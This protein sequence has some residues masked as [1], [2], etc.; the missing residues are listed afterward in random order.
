MNHMITHWWPWHEPEDKQAACK[1]YNRRIKCSISIIYFV[2]Q[3]VTQRLSIKW[4]INEIKNICFQSADG[5]IQSSKIKMYVPVYW[6]LASKYGIFALI[7]FIEVLFAMSRF[8][9][10]NVTSKCITFFQK[11]FNLHIEVPCDLRDVACDA[12]STSFMWRFMMVI[13]QENKRHI[14][15]ISRP[16]ICR[17]MAEEP[18]NV[19]AWTPGHSIFYSWRLGQTNN[20]FVSGIPPILANGADPGTFYGQIK[21]YK[22][23][24]DLIF[25]S[26]PMTFYRY[27]AFTWLDINTNPNAL[28]WRGKWHVRSH[29]FNIF[30]DVY[31]FRFCNIS[32]YVKIRW[33]TCDG[34]LI[35]CHLVNVFYHSSLYEIRCIPI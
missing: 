23:V 27:L 18:E 8:Q 14:S 9:S 32:V 20:T 30:K 6:P 17:Y 12:Q 33:K 3:D 34:F 24:C 29:L 25:E 2:V 15:L 11:R 28:A 21:I 7:K 4:Y 16:F 13:V 31:H 19:V 22:H 1:G 10:D 5:S 35:C 26:D